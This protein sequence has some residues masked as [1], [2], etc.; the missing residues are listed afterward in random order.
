MGQFARHVFVCTYGEY[1]PFD[2]SGAIHQ[3]LKDGV[4]L[5]GLKKSVRVNKA[6]CLDQCGN[7]PMVVVYPE[8]VWYAGVTPERA[9]RILEQHLVGGRTVEEWRYEAPAGANK[10]GK[11]MAD[12]D[13]KR[14][15]A[16]LKQD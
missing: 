14:P 15:E 2:G 10:N 7:G 11:R 5:A 3:L 1:C 6:G 13:S 4:K 12:I 8:N 16:A 9:A